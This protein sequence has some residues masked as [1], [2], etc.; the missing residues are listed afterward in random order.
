MHYSQL[1]HMV[2]VFRIFL[3]ILTISEMTLALGKCQ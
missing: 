3:F 1:S 2:S